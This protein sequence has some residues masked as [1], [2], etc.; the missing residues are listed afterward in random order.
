MIYIYGLADPR[1]GIIRYV[2]K[3]VNLE[4]RIKAHLCPNRT[5]CKHCHAWL[6]KLRSD[7]VKP[8]VAQLEALP[9]D[10]NWEDREVWWIAHFKANG[11]D[12]TN[13]MPGGEGN[14]TYGR[15]GKKNSLDHIR[16]SSRP[17]V[18]V[19]HTEEGNRKRADGVRKYYEQ[20]KIHVFQYSMDGKFIQEWD[21]AVDCGKETGFSHS[22]ITRACKD[23]S[24]TAYGFLW[25]H[26]QTESV[27]PY[28]KPLPSNTKHID[29]SQVEELLSQGI[30]KREIAH[31]IGVTYETLLRKMKSW[32]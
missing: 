2:G 5:G 27:S 14:A 4:R 28:K 9:D 21:S 25:R 23:I 31:I 15:L 8:S 1:N 3:T 32:K 11:N 22:N 7:G 10:A 24:R 18:P 6:A 19:R 13:I 17:G 20:N 12:L 16:K 29:R 26:K 30:L